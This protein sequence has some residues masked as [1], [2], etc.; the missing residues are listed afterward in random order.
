M[1]TTVLGFTAMADLYADDSFFGRLFRDASA[2]LTSDYTTRFH[3]EAVDFVSKIQ[4]VH[5]F[6]H[7]NLVAS[8]AK[9]KSAA[10]RKRREL[11]FS[12]GDLVWVVLTKDRLPVGEYNKLKS[13]KI[14]PVEVLERINPNAYKFRLPQHLR[15]AKSIRDPKS[16][17]EHCEEYSHLFYLV[18][19]VTFNNKLPAFRS[20]P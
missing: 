4:Q 9:Y 2:G 7:D 19:E 11:I 14:G 5:Q 1:S 20:N 17:N 6:A 13:R 8:T 10:D 18:F 3:G 16:S 15:T 12:P